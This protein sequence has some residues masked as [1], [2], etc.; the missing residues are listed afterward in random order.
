MR[1]ETTGTAIRVMVGFDEYG[2]VLMS[3]TRRRGAAMLSRRVVATCL[4][5]ADQLDPSIRADTAGSG[6][7]SPCGQGHHGPGYRGGKLSAKSTHGQLLKAS[8][9]S[10]LSTGITRQP[11]EFSHS[12]RKFVKAAASKW[13]YSADF[14]AALSNNCSE[15]PVPSDVAERNVLVLASC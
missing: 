3:T 7:A 10:A 1:T 14:S 11:L 6:H 5:F 12:N 4:V 13:A 9:H 2:V 15:R 8:N